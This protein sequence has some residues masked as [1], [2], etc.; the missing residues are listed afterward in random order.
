[1]SEFVSVDSARTMFRIQYNS[2]RH[3]V[4]KTL[5]VVISILRDN[6]PMQ[7]EI[8]MFDTITKTFSYKESTHHSSY[9]PH[10]LAT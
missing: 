8:G 5:P 2:R 3:A 9:A 4:D 6:F 1:M 10:K 7:A